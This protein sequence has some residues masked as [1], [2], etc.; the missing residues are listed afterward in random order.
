[1]TWKVLE[2]TELTRLSFTPCT[3]VGRLQTV[4]DVVRELGDVY[5]AAR[6]GDMSPAYACKFAYLLQVLRTT[7]ESAYLDLEPEQE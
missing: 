2:M 4:G 3:R 5:R 7:M 1:M 6:R